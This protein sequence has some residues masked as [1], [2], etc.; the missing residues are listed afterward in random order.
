MLD[1]PLDD[2]LVQM[3]GQL[4]KFH[5]LLTVDHGIATAVRKMSE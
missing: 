1:D 4:G 2:G 3:S 5:V